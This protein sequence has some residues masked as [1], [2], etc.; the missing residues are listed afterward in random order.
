MRGLAVCHKKNVIEN[1]INDEDKMPSKMPSKKAFKPLL[2]MRTMSSM[3][4][5]IRLRIFSSRIKPAL[6]LG[7]WK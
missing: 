6:I 7:I 5:E 2:S 4:M 1:N 3:L